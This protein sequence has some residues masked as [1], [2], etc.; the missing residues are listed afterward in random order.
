MHHW[1]TLTPVFSPVLSN[2]HL[3]AQGKLFHIGTG[4]LSPTE[5]QPPHIHDSYEIGMILEGSGFI[6]F[7]REVYPFEPGQV[8]IIND[9][10]PHMGYTMDAVVK[11][12]VVHFQPAVI[13]GSWISKMRAE[14]LL[15][16]VP[17]FNRSGPLL[18][19]DD[20]ITLTLR[21]VLQAIDTEAQRQD[22]AWE[23]VTSGLIVQAAGYL[24]R[25]LL[26]H[27]DDDSLDTKRRQA[28]LR[29]RPALTLIEQRFNKALTLD[30]LAAEAH[31]SK[32]HCCALFQTALR[33]TP[34]AYR[35]ARR[36]IEAERLLRTTD[37]TVREIA[38][39]VGFESA[40]A[41]NRLFLRET[42]MSPGQY[43]QEF[44]A[45]FQNIGS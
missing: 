2:A 37:Q 19:L 29:I 38:Y 14:T 16:F 40:Q 26:N 24:A 15:P 45:R 5:A 21:D 11:L 6:A 33:T 9:M 1:H 32:S 43:R 27:T 25:R 41:F 44:Y 17:D 7:G 18:P 22:N 31:L 20:P 3:I 35:N 13:N 12:F 28:L 4:E 42:D 39:S 34:I 30:E 23:V 8:Y 10:Q 36:I